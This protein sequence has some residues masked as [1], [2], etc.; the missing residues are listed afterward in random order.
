[1]D[2]NIRLPRKVKLRPDEDATLY[3]KNRLILV[4]ASSTAARKNQVLHFARYFRAEFNYDFVQFDGSGENDDSFQAWLFF[5][6]NYGDSDIP[7][8]ACCFRYREDYIDMPNFWGLQ[9][10]WLHPYFRSKGIFKNAFPI[11]R[12]RYGLFLPEYPISPGMA[13]FIEKHYREFKDFQESIKRNDAVRG[14]RIGQ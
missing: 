8:G 9:W 2:F 12:E 7:I 10:I 6:E 4:D 5:P 13:G 3:C 14:T 11:F 1:M